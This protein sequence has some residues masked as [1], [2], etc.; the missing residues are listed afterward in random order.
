M[1]GQKTT[2]FFFYL[3]QDKSSTHFEPMLFFLQDELGSW[4][5][6]DNGWG[7]EALSSAHFEPM[8]YFFTG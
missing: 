3:C 2:M 7:E 1:L 4:S 8:L 5:E 6:K